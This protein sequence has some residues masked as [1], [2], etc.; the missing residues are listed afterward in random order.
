[1]DGPKIYIY[2]HVCCIANWE[3][4]VANIFR[5][6]KNSGLYD[7]T[8]KIIC[9]VV[10]DRTN[11]YIAG[12]ELLKD[13]KIE[14]RYES[15]DTSC[16]ERKILNI[17]H[18]DSVASE[19]EFYVLYLHSKGVTRN[20]DSNIKKNVMDWVNYMLYFNVYRFKD[21]IK[22]LP[23]YDT[24]GVSLVDEPVLHYSG[25]FW[26]SKSSH[27]KKLTPEIDECYNGPEFWITKGYQNCENNF[28]ESK[29]YSLWNS[30]TDHYMNSYSA[31]SYAGKSYMKI[32]KNKI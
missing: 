15:N 22:L 13:K 5:A 20:N 4:V 23:T 18:Q 6:L 28:T 21:I 8:E 14:I 24:V 7:V 31:E 25:N 11:N 3:F 19:E 17:L 29:H 26:W 10:G 1:M 16:Y 2:F 30:N 27:I 9:T 12:N 32:V